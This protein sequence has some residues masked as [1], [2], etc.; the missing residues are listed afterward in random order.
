[1]LLSS[2]LVPAIEH[3]ATLVAFHLNQSTAQS[4]QTVAT[5]NFG[6]VRIVL[7]FR[8]QITPRAL[9]GFSA[10]LADYINRTALFLATR[11]STGLAESAPGVAR[12]R[13][14]R[15]SASFALTLIGIIHAL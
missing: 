7:A 8:A 10:L 4:L 5:A 1:M 12:A 3:P 15:A 13:L 9:V 11:S 2:P 14:N 6:L